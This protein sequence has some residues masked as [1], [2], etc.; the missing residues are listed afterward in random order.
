V[1]VSSRIQLGID[2]EFLQEI[3][4]PSTAKELRVSTEQVVKALTMAHSLRPERYTILGEK[5]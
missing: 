1:Y 2:Q 5:G 4:A 3:G